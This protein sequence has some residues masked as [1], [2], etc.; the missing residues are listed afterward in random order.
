MSK[1]FNLKQKNSFYGNLRIKQIK[2][3]RIYFVLLLSFLVAIPS[4]CFSASSEERQ[5][6]KLSRI[7]NESERLAKLK[8]LTQ[9]FLTHPQQ[10]QFIWVWKEKYLNLRDQRLTSDFVEQIQGK[11]SGDF[12]KLQLNVSSS[13]TNTMS[14]G[15]YLL[16]VRSPEEAIV[17]D[18]VKLE[19]SG[20]LDNTGYYLNERLFNQDLKK[21]GVSGRIYS[22]D[23]WTSIN[24]PNE[25]FEVWSGERFF[26]ALKRDPSLA[27]DIPTDALMRAR[28]HMSNPPYEAA[29]GGRGRKLRSAIYR[30]CFL[31]H[32]NEDF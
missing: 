30:R 9:P 31:G 15:N 19:D 1:Q 4:V 16:V 7:Q 6:L 21:L 3:R 28:K 22:R 14:Y 12:K 29:S 5:Y 23:G 27:G 11:L 25:N 13:V 32:L 26:E 10:F 17:L 8:T 2:F 20:L 18:Y 24:N